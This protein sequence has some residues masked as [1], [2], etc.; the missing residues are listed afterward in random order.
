[1]NTRVKLEEA[2]YIVCM[3][4]SYVYLTL[5]HALARNIPWRWDSVAFLA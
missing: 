1:M 2:L 3:V 4:I 5:L